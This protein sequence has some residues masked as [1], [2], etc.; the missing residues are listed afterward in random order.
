MELAK[1]KCQEMD[2]TARQKLEELRDRSEAEF[3]WL[4][5]SEDDENERYRPLNNNWRG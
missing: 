4:R 1:A 2:V 3:H 5:C